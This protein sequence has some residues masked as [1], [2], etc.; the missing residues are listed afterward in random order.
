MKRGALAALAVVVMTAA[1]VV[2]QPLA[3]ASFGWAI[4]HYPGSARITSEN[5]DLDYLRHG[6]LSRHS[7][8]EANAD[9]GQVER[10]YLER[11]GPVSAADEQMG[12]SC[13]G[14]RTSRVVVSIVY[15]VS[16]TLCSVGAGTRVMVNESAFFSPLS[17]RRAL[18]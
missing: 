12:E 5:I 4:G 6:W 18:P 8:Y 3:D 1:C 9:R 11:Y 17:A 2:G 7:V 13:S 10:W 14:F 16:I 15:A